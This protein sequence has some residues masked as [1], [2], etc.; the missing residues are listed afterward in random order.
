MDAH[1]E[2]SELNSAQHKPIALTFTDGFTREQSTVQMM[3]PL[4]VSERREG[5]LNIDG[6]LDDWFAE[7]AIQSGPLAQMFSR[8]ALQSQQLLLAA[9]PS[10]IYTGW[11]DENFLCGLQSKRYRRRGAACDKKLGQLP[12][13][14][15]LG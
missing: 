3:L 14:P 7:D 5:R 4:A 1:V 13:S 12:V 10:S 8:P 15:R 6:K 9:T 2:P 11:A